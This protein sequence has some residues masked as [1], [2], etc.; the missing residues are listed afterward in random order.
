MNVE[1]PLGLGPEWYSTKP[2]DTRVSDPATDDEP[3][4][5]YWDQLAA[6][7]CWDE[8]Y[9]YEPHDQGEPVMTMEPSGPVN[10]PA[11]AHPAEQ[12]SHQDVAPKRSYGE[13]RPKRVPDAGPDGEPERVQRVLR[14]V[15]ASLDGQASD[16]VIATVSR[17]AREKAMLDR[18]ESSWRPVIEGVLEVLQFECSALAGVGTI[19]FS[20][21]P[22]AANHSAQVAEELELLRHVAPIPNPMSAFEALVEAI[23]SGITKQAALELIRSVDEK[24]TAAVKMKHFR[25][26]PPPTRQREVQNNTWARTAAE[27]MDEASAA[28]GSATDLIL[29]SGYPTLDIAASGSAEMPGLIKPGEFWVGAA[30]TGHGKSAFT[31]RVFTSMLEDL[32]SGWGFSEARGILGFTEEEAWD[33][34]KAAQLD[35]GQPYHHLANN[36]VLA[37]LGESRKRVV[38]VVYDLVIDAARRAEA[39]GSPITEFLPYFYFLDYIQA[40]KEPGE[41]PDTEGVA[42]TADLMMRGIAAW[43]QEM[44][45]SISGLDFREYAGMD[46]PDGMDNHRV[47]VFCLSQLRKEGNDHNVFFRKGRSTVSDFTVVDANGVPMWDPMEDDYAIPNR[48]DLRGSGVLLNHATGLIFFHRS[49]PTASVRRDPSGKVIGLTDTRARFIVPK[50]RKSV[51]MPYIPVRFDSNP[52]GFRGQFYDDLAWENCVVNGRMEVSDSCQREG[53]PILPKR[54]ARSPWSVKY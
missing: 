20:F 51:S 6:Q 45:G 32:T 44:M 23:Q 36:A 49:R 48:S 10:E 47:A 26:I 21:L 31:R 28:E 41:N 17:I 4:S 30:G 18:V 2:E 19:D 54:P 34:A 50:A 1:D 25:S 43:D 52:E 33:V 37:K 14:E 15:L 9:G 24:A 8:D 53:D 12:A 38:Q 40:I 46:W 3:P 29:S 7:D 39:T 22:A 13:W 16:S 35:K 27:W 5:E 42:R 11:P